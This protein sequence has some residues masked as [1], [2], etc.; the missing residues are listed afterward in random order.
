[1]ASEI[2]LLIV[3]VSLLVVIVAMVRQRKSARTVQHHAGASPEL[4]RVSPL[5]LPVSQVVVPPH[6]P[7]AV[8]RAVIEHLRQLEQRSSPGL[9]AQVMP[10]FL[11]DTAA[12]LKA[13]QA[14]VDQKDPTAAHR[15]AHTLH[16]SAAAI[17]AASMVSNCAEIIREVRHGVFD[18][19]DG[20]IIA[21]TLD[22]EAI[23]RA[24]EAHQ[25]ADA[26]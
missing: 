13:L 15:V 26:P 9:S 18:R 4:W 25:I 14:A 19:C 1:M 17:G 21:L 3:V 23:R 10:V 22:F 11:K 2:L 24:A 16:G 8:G 7:E 20:L 6:D 12:R 5:P